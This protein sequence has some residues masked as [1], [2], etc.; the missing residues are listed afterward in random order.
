MNP[1]FVPVA[2]IFPDEQSIEIFLLLRVAAMHFMMNE[3]VDG[4]KQAVS[5]G[6]VAPPAEDGTISKL[7]AQINHGY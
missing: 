2:D 4:V 7:L 6:I 3:F 1:K 5:D